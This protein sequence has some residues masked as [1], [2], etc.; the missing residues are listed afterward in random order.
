MQH[1]ILKKFRY[2][3]VRCRKSTYVVHEIV[4]KSRLLNWSVYGNQVPLCVECHEWAHSIGTE[5][6]GKILRNLHFR[7]LVEYRMVIPNIK[8]FLRKF[9]KEVSDNPSTL[10]IPVSDWKLI[11]ET[12][13]A[14][15]EKI[16]NLEELLNLEDDDW[17]SD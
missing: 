8:S 6:S 9:D 17:L 7:R 3:C 11:S 4:P 14:Q 13:K 16:R 1:E 15:E 10:S 12:L 5:K 2:K